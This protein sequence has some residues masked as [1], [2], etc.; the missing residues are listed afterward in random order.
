MA[1]KNTDYTRTEISTQ[2][3]ATP[4][5]KRAAHE[6]S[7]APVVRIVG[8]GGVITLAFLGL[9]VRLW[10]LQVVQGDEH[11][12]TAQE[13]GKGVPLRIL[14]VRGVITD[15]AGNPLVANTTKFAVLVRPG[16]GLDQFPMPIDDK[17][18]EKVAKKSPKLAER[19]RKKQAIAIAKRDE[20]L[21]KLQNIAGIAPENA[22]K[23]LEAE[24]KRAIPG[25]PLTITEGITDEDTIARLAEQGHLLRGVYTDVITVRRYASDQ[26]AAHVLGYVKDIDEKSLKEKKRLKE[27]YGPTDKIGVKGLE[28]SYEKILRGVPGEKEIGK[29]GSVMSSTPPIAGDS[30]QLHLAERAQRAAENAIEGKKGAIVAIDPETGG[31]LA[32]ASWPKYDPNVMQMP[33]LTSEMNTYLNDNKDKPQINR[34]VGPEPPGSTYKI[35][36]ATAGLAEKVIT[37]DKAFNCNGAIHR[38]GGHLNCMSKHGHGSISLIGAMS[39]SCNVFYGETGIRLEEKEEN[40][41]QKWGNLFGLGTKTH[42]DF[43]DYDGT[44]PSHNATHEYRKIESRRDW[45]WGDSAQASIGQGFVTV[46]PLQMAR[47]VGAISN[48]GIIY[49]PHF[50]KAIIHPDGKKEAIPP[51][52]V[53][54]LPVSKDDLAIVRRGLRACIN[55]GTGQKANVGGGVDVMGKTGSAE[56]GRRLPGT[57]KQASHAWFVGVGSK[58]GKKIAVCVFIDGHGLDLHGGADAAPPAARVISAYFNDTDQVPKIS[59]PHDAYEE[60]IEAGKKAQEADAVTTTQVKPSQATSE[61]DQPRRRSGRRRNRSRR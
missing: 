28:R 44:I 5:N 39:K 26:Y 6:E 31:V 11:L 50:V 60:E 43:G 27:N 2:Y 46:T 52:I 17:E 21:K 45:G 10:Y 1:N 24:Q 36:T 49:E 22:I 57:T 14:P 47:V 48:G 18:I 20:I 55:S 61:S 12:K 15:N 59:K 13:K 33:V 42:A 8:M 54:K 34:A 53:N 51:K 23:R 29:N 25:Q 35:V 30:I 16:D 7:S 4:R 41:I 58:N 19:W 32:L 38:K 3:T 9:I 40:T 37:E 56:L